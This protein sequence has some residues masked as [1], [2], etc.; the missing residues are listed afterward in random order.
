M[1]TK[2][3]GIIIK[4]SNYKE[5]DKLASIFSLEEGIITAK[6]TGV[7]K[8]KAK[9]KAVAQPFCFADF[10]LNTKADSNTVTSANI[11]DN[12]FGITANYQKTI[13]AYIVL[14]I[15]QSILPKQKTEQEIFVL[16]IKALKDIEQKNEYISLINFILQFINFSGMKVEFDCSGTILLDKDTGNFTSAKSLWTV[17]IDKKVYNLLK[18]INDSG[19]ENERDEV[20]EKLEYSETIL[21]QA[22]R[23]TNSIMLAKFGVELKTFEFV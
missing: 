2:V 11:I 9:F 6:F 18:V 4:L 16:T 10:V 15:L 13:C 21:K 14:D 19:E 23:L 1:D 8:E 22:L 20:L 17:P 5:A 12:F 3:K 7:K